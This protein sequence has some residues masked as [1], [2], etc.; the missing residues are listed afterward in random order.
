MRFPTS[1]PLASRRDLEVQF[2]ALSFLV[3][4]H[5]WSQMQDNLNHPTPLDIDRTQMAILRLLEGFA[6]PL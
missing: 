3:D 1:Q 4:R 6:E 5:E 2:E